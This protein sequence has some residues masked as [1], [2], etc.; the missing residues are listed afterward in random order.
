VSTRSGVDE[1]RKAVCDTL[2]VAIIQEP[3]DAPVEKVPTEGMTP[4]AM[5]KY[6]NSH[7]N[8]E[9]WAV[10][11]VAASDKSN[12]DV[13]VNVNGKQFLLQRGVEVPV[14]PMVL[15]ALKNAVQTVYPDTT[16]MLP[17]SRH[18][19]PFSVIKQAI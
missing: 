6:R 10:I 1:I 12:R 14:P 16:S 19:Y 4:L 7:A 13:Q 5:D 11:V 2:G 18:S 3:P 9:N 17:V 15:E 8:R